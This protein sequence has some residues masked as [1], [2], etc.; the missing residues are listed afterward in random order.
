M[1]NYI[2]KLNVWKQSLGAALSSSIIIFIY[3]GCEYG[4]DI[5]FLKFIGL[6]ALLC[7]I[8]GALSAMLS[9]GSVIVDDEI[10]AIDPFLGRGTVKL[11]NAKKTFSFNPFLFIKLKDGINKS[12]VRIPRPFW[13]DDPLLIKDILEKVKKNKSAV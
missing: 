9:M 12:V 1:K 2:I 8:I 13:A 10:E 11:S 6:I 7:G 5:P 4:F 3:A